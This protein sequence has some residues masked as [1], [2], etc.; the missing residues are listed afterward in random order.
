VICFLIS[1]VSA[2]FLSPKISAVLLGFN[3]FDYFLSNIWILVLIQLAFGAGVGIISS[4]IVVRK[5]L[6]V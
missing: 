3:T 5:Y 2:Y 4:F 1:A 6:D